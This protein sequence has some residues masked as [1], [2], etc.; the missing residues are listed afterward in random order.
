MNSEFEM[1]MMGEL[2]FFLGLQIKQTPVGTSIH[3]QKY[4]KELLKKYDMNE[5]ESN[6]TPIGTTTKLDK[7]E[8]VLVYVQSFSSV[9]RNHI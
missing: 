2:N 4:I 5:A 7:D 8:P 3:Q 6:D 1:S 9:P